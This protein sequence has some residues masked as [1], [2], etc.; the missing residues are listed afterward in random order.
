MHLTLPHFEEIVTHISSISHAVVPNLALR[1]TCT[2]EQIYSAMCCCHVGFK[3]ICPHLPINAHFRPR[4]H[5]ARYRISHMDTFG[6]KTER[7]NFSTLYYL[8]K[9]LA[10]KCDN[11]NNNALFY[12]GVR[13]PCAIL[14]DGSILSR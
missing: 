9:Q 5:A 1:C 13:R 11:T 10:V 3:L 8:L 14:G 2:Q 6:I 4:R 12:N 7:T